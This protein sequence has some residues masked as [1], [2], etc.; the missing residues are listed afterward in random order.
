VSDGV[1][2]SAKRLS[3]TGGRLRRS[4]ASSRRIRGVGRCHERR[5]SAAR[6]LLN[7]TMEPVLAVDDSLLPSYYYSV[8]MTRYNEPHARLRMNQRNVSEAEVE[9]AL[10]TKRVSTSPTRRAREATGPR[11]HAGETCGCSIAG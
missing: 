4:I 8:T 1:D 5:S 3:P 7:P 11:S 9:E 10:W 6:V 2:G